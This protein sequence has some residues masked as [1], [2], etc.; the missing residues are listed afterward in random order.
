MS[1]LRFM[2]LTGRVGVLRI[3]RYDKIWYGKKVWFFCFCIFLGCVL[4]CMIG[5]ITLLYNDSKSSSM[6]FFLFRE[7]G[8]LPHKPSVSGSKWIVY[9]FD[10]LCTLLSDDAIF[11]SKYLLKC[12]P[13][14]EIIGFNVQFFELFIQLF[15]RFCISFAHTIPYRTVKMA[16]F[17]LARSLNSQ[18]YKLKA[19][20]YTLKPSNGELFI[21]VKTL[22]L[23]FAN[24]TIVLNNI[25]G[26]KLN[27]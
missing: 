10:I 22:T 4:K 24:E 12:F 20:N 3:L 19:T 5:I 23:I 13:I 14:I 11:F 17:V 1:I 8:S 26:K 25:D 15:G 16:G 2:H 6:I 9:A 27:Y 21:Y 7:T 18:K